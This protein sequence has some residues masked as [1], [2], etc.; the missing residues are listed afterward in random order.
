M[1]H[2]FEVTLLVIAVLALF[3]A[4]PLVISRLLE[5]SRRKRMM[6]KNTRTLHMHYESAHDAAQF[7]KAI[8]QMQPGESDMDV[9]FSFDMPDESSASAAG[10]ELEEMGFLVHLARGGR[11]PT[12]MASKSIVAKLEVVTKTRIGLMDL[13]GR[14]GGSYAEWRTLPRRKVS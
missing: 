1:M 3:G 5:A 4:M 12:L 7:Q 14:H 13:I 6:V 8:S 9:E 11:K 10:H 2:S